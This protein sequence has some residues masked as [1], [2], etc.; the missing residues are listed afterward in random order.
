MKIAY[1]VPMLNE[2][3][4]IQAFARQQEKYFSPEYDFKLLDW[5]S[6][7]RLRDELVYRRLPKRLAR[8]L[9]ERRHHGDF[10]QSVTTQELKSYDLIHYWIV[11]AAMAYPELP[12]VITCHGIEMLTS[13]VRYHRKNKFL[14]ALKSSKAIHANSNFTKSYLVDNHQIKPDKITVINPGID[15]SAFKFYKS[16]TG[17][18]VCIGTLT[19][20]VKRKNVPNIIKALKIL[21]T[22]Y[23]VDFV[24][25][26]AGDGAAKSLILREL[27]QAGIDYK[28]FGAISE[29]DK[30]NV[31]Y[32]ALDIFVLPPL[33]T[34]TD[35]EGFGIV[36]LEANACGIPVVAAATGGVPDAVKPGFS[37]E[38]ADPTDPKDIADKI[39][40]I[41]NSKK[42]YRASSRQW[43]QNFSQEKTAAGLQSLYE[44]VTK[45]V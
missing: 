21:K 32:P 39:R 42:D 36:F 16:S 37:G 13:Y 44:K 2:K 29:D 20:F 1:V 17:D 40:K 41:L 15:L 3:G 7:T 12:G 10:N 33:E 31:F 45:D 5:Y 14:E 23:G 30:L 8:S 35:V 9:L 27:K 4:G 28:Y 26:L 38:F 24:Y 18:K 34:P 43:A 11:D 19:R 25:Y 22:Q 6:P